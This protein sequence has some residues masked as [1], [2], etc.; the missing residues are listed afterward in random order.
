M[1]KVSPIAEYL[2]INKAIPKRDK[3]GCNFFSPEGMYIGRL[4]KAHVNNYTVY[5]LS[6]F[7]EGLK[8]MYTKSIAF[9]HQLAYVANSGTEDGIC[10]TPLK[11]FMRK[12]FVDFINGTSEITDSE[13]T[14]TNKLHLIDIDRKTGAG[15]F[16][17]DE[18]FRYITT[19]TNSEQKKL[20]NPKFK[21]IQH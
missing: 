3:F 11:T 1:T 6:A 12:V 9:G 18:P 5:N 10:I 15:L 2:R 14:L 19:I 20:K 7:G 8:T 17:I 16:D 13:R 4:S 21:F